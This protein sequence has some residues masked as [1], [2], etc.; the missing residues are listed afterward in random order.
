MIAAAVVLALLLAAAGMVFGPF[1]FLKRPLKRV[2]TSGV[3]IVNDKFVT[4]GV[5]PYGDH[6]VA[7]IDAGIDPEAKAIRAELS[8]RR[9]GRGDVKFIFLTHG[10]SDH[11]GGIAQFP[12]AQVMALGAEV[13]IVEGRSTGGGPVLR[14][15]PPKP[16]G[17]RLARTLHDGEVVPLGTLPVRVFA[18]P[19]HTPGSAAFAI[20]ANLFLGD[21][22]NHGKDGRLKASPRVF[23]TS[24][25]QN[26]QSLAELARR[27]VNDRS[28]KT[29]VFSHSAPMLDRGA[30]PLAQF[31]IKSAS[32]EWAKG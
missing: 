32:K 1:I 14:F 22:A 24:A 8:R 27:L 21:S 11:V 18:V 28:I 6:E 4:V 7:L 9:L 10:H 12:N 3:C 26:R 15:K 2:E 13:D 5:V 16:T 17:I 25:A 20:G 30:E 19:G 29:L 23:C 31:A